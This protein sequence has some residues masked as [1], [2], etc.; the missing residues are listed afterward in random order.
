MHNNIGIFASDPPEHGSIFSSNP[1]S[2][3]GGCFES[4]LDEWWGHNIDICALVHSRRMVVYNIY[5]LASS[6]MFTSG[7]HVLI[8]ASV[9][10]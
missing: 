9:F 10:L 6:P 8:S 5:L 2:A 1:L 7:F 3:H 4:A